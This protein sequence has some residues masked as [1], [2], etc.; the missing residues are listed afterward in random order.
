MAW[1]KTGSVTIVQGQT[2]V[3]GTGTRFAANARVGDA[4]RGPDGLWYEVVNIASEVT[5]GIYPAY[6]GASVTSNTDYV[7]APMQGYVKDSAD[8]LRKITDSFKDI[9]L[10][11]QMARDAREGAETAQAA[12]LVSETNAAQSASAA[13]TSATN[14][15]NSAT[16]SQTARTG[17]EAAKTAAETAKTSAETART[18][19]QSSA[20]LAQQWAVNPVNSPVSDTRY[21]A[22]HWAMKAA[23]SAAQASTIVGPRLT[24]IANA[25]LAV[26]DMLIADSTNTMSKIATS[27]SGRA[28]LSGTPAQGRTALELGTASTM[29]VTTSNTDITPNR[30]LKV[31]DFGLGST[32]TPTMDDLTAIWVFASYLV[33]AGS[34]GL[35]AEAAATGGVLLAL[36]SNFGFLIQLSAAANNRRVWTGARAGTTGAVTW[37]EVISSGDFGIGTT[38][39]TTVTTA[40]MDSTSLGAGTYRCDP[41]STWR[42]LAAGV[43]GVWTSPLNNVNSNA[44]I[45]VNY[46]TGTLF[47]RGRYVDNFKEHYNTG[48]ITG[49]VSQTSGVPTGAIIETGNTAN[50]TY[51]KYADGTMICRHTIATSVAIDLAYIGGFRSGQVTWAYPANFVDTPTVVCSSLVNFASSAMPGNILTTQTGLFYFANQTIAAASRSV[52]AVAIGRWF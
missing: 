17:S 29:D 22:Y 35:P 36:R 5:L 2:S 13:Q 3:S 7:I 48:N 18:A 16:A 50:G 21:S 38:T 33:P 32:T 46:L 51:T 49:T 26:N 43:Y 28:V 9:D 24:S 11:V 37:K 40:Q 15:Q 27:A 14:S 42:G 52:S 12:A 4:F 41:T 44:Q 6:Q 31:G 1:Y 45:A 10:E 34:N 47:A 20:T 23:D 39:G 25:V 8:R 30:L 19:A